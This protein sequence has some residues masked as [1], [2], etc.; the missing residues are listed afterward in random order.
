MRRTLGHRHRLGEESPARAVTPTRRWHPAQ[1]APLLL[2]CGQDTPGRSG[3]LDFDYGR[4]HVRE[5]VTVLRDLWSGRSRSKLTTA[6]V[7]VLAEAAEAAEEAG[8]SGE[9]REGSA[10]GPP[11]HGSKCRCDAKGWGS[12]CFRR[13]ARGSWPTSTPSAAS[14]HAPCAMWSSGSPE[15][16]SPAAM[17]P[18]PWAAPC[19]SWWLFGWT[20][21]ASTAMR[22]SARRPRGNRWSS[23]CRR[24]AADPGPTTRTGA[25]T[26]PTAMTATRTATTE[27]ATGDADAACAADS[28]ALVA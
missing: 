15:A 26:T 14:P 22:P 16:V 19:C 12:R 6:T 28:A 21:R 1:L 18:P 10:R 8:E 3:Q 23:V 5:S 25:A 27:T 2:S 4:I 11:G 7:A 13:T 20:A 9:P 17:R 24:R